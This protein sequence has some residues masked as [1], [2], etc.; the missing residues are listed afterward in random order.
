MNFRIKI[1]IFLCVF[2]SGCIQN[3]NYIIKNIDFSL[4][5]EVD[6]NANGLVIQDNSNQEMKSPYIDHLIQSNIKSNLKKWANARIKT[7]YATS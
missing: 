7:T 6:F 1:F 2:L 5:S 3:K 4:Y